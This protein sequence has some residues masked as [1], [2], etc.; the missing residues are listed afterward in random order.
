MHFMFLLMFMCQ[1][2]GMLDMIRERS[3]GI[4]I[5]NRT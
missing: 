4:R 2:E 1:Y 5:V 3:M